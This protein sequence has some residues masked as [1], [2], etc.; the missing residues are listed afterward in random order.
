[1]AKNNNAL[2]WVVF[3]VLALVVGYLVGST[4][5]G[6]IIGS[7]WNVRGGTPADG[8]GGGTTSSTIKANS[9]DADDNCEVNAI[10]S[11]NDRSLIL[12]TGAT[13]GSQRTLQIDGE[14]IIL[15]KLGIAHGVGFQTND[16]GSLIITP[17]SGAAKIN[18]V[19]SLARLGA[20]NAVELES[21]DLGSFVVTP[22]SGSAKIN[23]DLT[24][25][26]VGSAGGV[27]LKSNEFGS[28]TV[29]PQ[30]GA[31]KIEGYL[32]ITNLT[33]SGNA[34]VCVNSAGLIYRSLTACR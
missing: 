32:S 9:C 31:A 30:S 33:G 22:G 15:S 2:W 19:L 26:R 28:L 25:A 13:A 34:Y 8:G 4:L 16:L 29:T 14:Q 23:A 18:A 17:E 5:T 10:S 24:L 11:P 21:N 27:V 7:R 20:A 6:N 3:I 1:M 12:S